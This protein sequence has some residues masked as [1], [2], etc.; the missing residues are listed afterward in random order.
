[1][2]R[3]SARAFVVVACVTLG[4][5]LAPAQVSQ[6]AVRA[7]SRGGGG[8]TPSCSSPSNGFV[9]GD[10][11]ASTGATLAA[12]ATVEFWGAKWAK[13]NPLSGGPAPD[14]FKGYAD[15]VTSS[16]TSSTWT[17]NPGNSS[18]PPAS[19]TSSITVIVTSAVT[20]SGPAISGDVVAVATV[21]PHA[22]YAADPGHAGTGTVVSVT[23][24]G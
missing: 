1:M 11:N 18:D 6:A 21:T 19:L 24:C 17:A 20:Q 15:T 3:W 7:V 10:L 9:V 8:G 13:D 23:P 16:G 2:A 22:G 5:V 14:A 12:G 4:A